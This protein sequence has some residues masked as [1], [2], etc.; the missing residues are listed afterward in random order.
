MAGP[1]SNDEAAWRSL[2]DTARSG[3][4]D[5]YLSILFAPRHKQAALIALAAFVAEIG[6]IPAVVSDPTIGEIRLQWWR[7]AVADG[8]KGIATGNPVADALA[9]V[10]REHALPLGD[11]HRFIDAASFAFS[12]DLLAD[13]TALEQHL[14]ATEGIPFSHAWQILT[15]AP[16]E[17][18]IASAAGLAY[19]LARDLGRLPVL[20]HNGGFTVPGSLLDARGVSRDQLAM[21]SPPPE[22]AAGIERAALE[23]EQAARAALHRIRSSRPADLV[24]GLPA[25]L[26]LAMVEPHFHAQKRKGYRRLEHSLEVMPLS[27]F[28]HIGLARL[29]RR[30]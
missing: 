11:L 24:A 28:W 17:P 29:R 4:P 2:Q 14:A 7:D 19:G 22:I 21:P 12:G 1:G 30:F 10:V 16:L 25:I 15:G 13:T 27:R 26:P 5:R 20:L 18:S 23:L 3:E 8:A 6:R 9:G